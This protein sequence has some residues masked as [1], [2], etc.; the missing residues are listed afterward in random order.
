[1]QF[2]NWFYLSWTVYFTIVMHFFHLILFC[3]FHFTSSSQ[4]LSNDERFTINECH[5]GI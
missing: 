4:F 2:S 3:F 5:K 1:M